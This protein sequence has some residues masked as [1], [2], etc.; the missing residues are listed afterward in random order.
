M[1]TKNGA[2]LKIKNQWLDSEGGICLPPPN[3]CDRTPPPHTPSGVVLRSANPEQADDLSSGTPWVVRNGQRNVWART[4][5]SIWREGLILST[6]PCRA[7]IIMKRKE[8]SGDSKNGAKASPM[9][10][11]R[12]VIVTR[13]VQYAFLGRHDSPIPRYGSG[14]C[15][16]LAAPSSTSTT[17][18]AGIPEY[19]ITSPATVLAHVIN[20]QRLPPPTLLSMLGFP[21]Y[22]YG[23]CE[24]L[25]APSST[26]TTFNA[27]IP[28]YSITSPATVLAHVINWQRLPPPTLLSLLGFR[29]NK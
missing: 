12:S 22:G 13:A 23:T 6:S 9:F 10:A 27:G 14:T 16:K 19:S 18:I 21:R 4:V 11:G 26:D 3:L 29:N 25:A 1:A 17:F 20:W 8:R 2:H 7:A 15:D 24:K 28:E 5:N